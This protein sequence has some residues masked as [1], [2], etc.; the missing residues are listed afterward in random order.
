MAMIELAG[1][2]YEYPDGRV[3]LS[4]IDLR[5][6]RGERVAVLGPNGAGKTTL[7]L[8][9]NGTLR[10]SAGTVAISGAVI[11]DGSVRDVRCRVGVVFQDPDDQLFMP[12]VFDD[13]AFGPANFGVSGAALVERVDAALAAVGMASAADRVPHHL[14]FG[15]KRRVAV[16]TVLACDPDVLVLDEPSCNLDP[17][18]RRELVEILQTLPQTIV[19]VTHDLLFAAELCSRAIVLDGGRLAVDQPI[20]ELLDDASLLERHALEL[21]VLPRRVR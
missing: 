6:G 19:I 3:A 5:V 21:P 8:T 14:S 13:V 16:A 7:A 20:D 4:G 18:S 12:T 17:R 11:N 9:L 10:A 15:E 2:Y 1:V